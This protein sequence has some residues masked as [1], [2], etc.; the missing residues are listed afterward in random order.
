MGTPLWNRN[1]TPHDPPG[2]SRGFSST[3][4]F[5]CSPGKQPVATVP[6]ELQQPLPGSIPGGPTPLLPRFSLINSSLINSSGCRWQGWLQLGAAL[7]AWALMD[8][9]FP[10]P[11]IPRNAPG[12]QI[13][14]HCRVKK[15]EKIGIGTMQCSRSREF[16]HGAPESWC[17]FCDYLE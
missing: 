6:W 4:A 10:L 9:Q 8:A 14:A 17:W 13:Q 12:L 16:R 3:L 7:P 11:A 1:P 5:P 15:R 2:A